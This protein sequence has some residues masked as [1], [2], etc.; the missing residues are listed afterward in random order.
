MA[1]APGAYGARGDLNGAYASGSELSDGEYASQPD[2]SGSEWDSDAELGGAEQYAGGEQGSPTGAEE[3][4]SGAGAGGGLEAGASGDEEPQMQEEIKARLLAARAA[5]EALRGRLAAAEEQE[6][7]IRAALH[8]V[9]ALAARVA[10]YPGGEDAGYAALPA[11]ELQRLADANAVLAAGGPARMRCP[12]TAAKRIGEEEDDE[13]ADN[14]LRG[15]GEDDRALESGE[16]D[17]E[18]EDDEGAADEAR[19][20]GGDEQDSDAE[21]L[22]SDADASGEDAYDSSAE[23]SGSGDEAYG[24][25]LEPYDSADE[26]AGSGEEYGSDPEAYGGGDGEYGSAEEYGSDPEAYG[27]ADGG[28]GSAP[29]AYGGGSEWE[30]DAEGGTETEFLD[31]LGAGARRGVVRG[32]LPPGRRR[33]APPVPA[34]RRDGHRQE[35]GAGRAGA[36]HARS[37]R[38]GAPPRRPGF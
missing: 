12:W 31:G 28:Y 29:D 18:E 20:S 13:G 25:D 2:D 15:S 4:Y 17:W 38:C 9:R 10:A 1:P 30:A 37:G 11:S 5:R 16:E 33:P 6:D 19:G 21:A 26:A 24:S 27:G 35:R 3:G 8:V 32:R 23:A 22:G 7:R 34:D 36:L 14:D